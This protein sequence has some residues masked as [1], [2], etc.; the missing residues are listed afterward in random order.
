MSCMLLIRIVIRLPRI[1]S[2]ESP[3]P[4]FI[5]EKSDAEL[6]GLFE[7]SFHDIY[8]KKLQLKREARELPRAEPYIP[9]L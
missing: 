3:G 5:Y 2:D 7:E 9:P 6:G 4:G 8:G 1:N